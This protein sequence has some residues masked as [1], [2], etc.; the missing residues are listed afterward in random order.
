MNAILATGGLNDVAMEFG[1]VIDIGLFLLICGLLAL[2]WWKH[3]L[4][5][6]VITSL[7]VILEGVWLEPWTVLAPSSDPYDAYWVFRLRVI[8]AVWVLLFIVTAVCLTRI[9]WHRKQK[10]AS[11]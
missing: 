4:V 2:S 11:V 6:I 10:K 1:E 7:L 9:I 3:S 8:C 5:F